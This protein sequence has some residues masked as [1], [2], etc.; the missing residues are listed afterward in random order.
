MK[1]GREV[2]STCSSGRVVDVSDRNVLCM[3]LLGDKAVLGSADH[4]LK[5]L[6][7]RG[8]QVLRNLYTKRFGHTEWVTSVS[9][10][11]DG[12][13]VSGA[14]DSKL[15]LW[16]ASGAQCADLTGHMGSISRLRTHAQGH[17][18]ISASY[19]RTLRAWDLGRKRQV[20]CC[21]GHS[22]PILEFTWADDVVASGDRGGTVC[23]WNAA[24]GAHV[25]TL[26]GHK[27]H[28]TAML[29]LPGS[30]CGLAAERRPWSPQARRTGASA[31]GTC[32]RG[33]TRTRFLHTP[34]AP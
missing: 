33:S 17:V 30:C 20:A 9:H 10:C 3:S 29:A 31:C 21:T 27:G 32:G 2:R 24:T 14:A 23:L 6:G 11:P 7:V 22:A 1:H 12:R 19:D 8:G 18:A 13:V 26:R 34:E 25:G 28:V 15:C 4:G 5:E 16:G